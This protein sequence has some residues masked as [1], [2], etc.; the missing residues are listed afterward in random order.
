MTDDSHFQDTVAQ[1]VACVRTGGKIY[2]LE[3]VRTQKEAW[4]RTAD[5]YR[6]AFRRCGC[7]CVQSYPVRNGRGVLLYAI[8]YGLIPRR[9]MPAL[10]K[11]EIRTARY[12]RP[13]PWVPY[14]DYLFVFSKR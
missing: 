3:Q 4:Q 5:E 11:H 12:H 8:R 6:T 14:Q 13:A 7:S 2:L 1:I 9:W 10:A